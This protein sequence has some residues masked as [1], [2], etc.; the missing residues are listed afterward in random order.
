M[1]SNARTALAALAGI[2]A[3]TVV[4]AAVQ[5]ISARLYPM[6]PGPDGAGS[7]QMREYIAGLPLV[8]FVL[9]LVSWL[10]GTFI[11]G[12]VAARIAGTQAMLGSGAVG[13]FML[14]ATIANLVKFP[15]PVWIAVAAVVGIPAAA[16]LAGRAGHLG[17]RPPSFRP[18]APR[19]R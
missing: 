7:A 1:S 11:G 5:L 4:V 9:V 17:V 3:A 15:P 14:A 8:A 16:W 10:V 13:A 6:P 18:S 12:L 2:V 19:D